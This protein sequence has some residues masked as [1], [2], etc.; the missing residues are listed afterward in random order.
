MWGAL[1]EPMLQ[2]SELLKI[3]I[4]KGINHKKYRKHLN[5]LRF[6]MDLPPVVV[7]NVNN[8]CN[9]TCPHCYSS[10]KIHSQS[11]EIIQKEALYIID[12]LKA[13]GITVIIFSGGEPLLRNDLIYLI[14]YAN[15]LGI[16]CHLSTNGTLI[17][18]DIAHKL[19]EAGVKY[20]GVS[21]DGLDGFNNKYRGMENAFKL[22]W[23]GILN[24]QNAGMATGIRITVTSYN[25]DQVMPL[26]ELAIRHHIP[27]FYLSH[28]VYGG[29]GEAYSKYD[30][31]KNN[32]KKLMKA[33]FD[34][35]VEHIE[36]EIPLSIVTG[37]NDA[38]GVF[39]YLYVKKLFG[40]E[41]ANIL[42][43]LLEARGGNSAGEKIINIDYKGNVH[44]DQFWQTSECGNILHETLSNIL[45]S[46]LIQ[47][48]KNRK[49][50]L[51]GDC[52]DCEYMSICRGSHRERALVTFGDLWL[53][54]PSCYIIKNNI[55]SFF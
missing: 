3:V 12:S 39:L 54:D 45:Q 53:T 7:W 2:I 10:A 27:R 1:G 36:N 34:K 4:E 21:I 40:E 5:P 6:R 19:K 46:E 24:A 35:A 33:L 30:M 14:E 28:L 22:S 50:F 52:K 32:N 37:G 20:V 15:N 29:R 47:S 51:K 43:D 48:L 18:Q 8:T 44:P 42:Y 25:A 38:D 55:E 41:K 16:T 49:L 31:D 17:T 11:D 9:M 23:D 13:F 26:M